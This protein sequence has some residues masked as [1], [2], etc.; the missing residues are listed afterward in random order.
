MSGKKKVELKAMLIKHDEEKKPVEQLYEAFR[1]REL[2]GFIARQ[3]D[4]WA[5]RRGTSAITDW[6]AKASWSC[7]NKESALAALALAVELQDAQVN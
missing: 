2:V 7:A 3:A 1:G 4:L 5:W 6:P